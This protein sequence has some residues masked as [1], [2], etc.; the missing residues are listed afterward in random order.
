MKIL[1]CDLKEFVVE[2]VVD[3]LGVV[4]C[5]H[6]YLQARVESMSKVVDVTLECTAKIHSMLGHTPWHG[7]F[8]FCTKSISAVQPFNKVLI[9]ER[10]RFE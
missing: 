9:D 7:L 2:P 1:S 6:G 5:I 8:L 4:Q 3:A 10:T